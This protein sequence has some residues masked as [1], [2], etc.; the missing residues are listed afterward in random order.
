MATT[1]LTT[2]PD[3]LEIIENYT[4]ETQTVRLADGSFAFCGNGNYY[5][6]AVVMIPGYDYEYGR[7]VASAD[8]TDAWESLAGAGF[9]SFPLGST[10]CY[11]DRVATT[12]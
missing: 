6:A 10:L 5:R 11:E 12:K 4:D 8:Y 7:A 2:D 1:Y 9:D 3:T